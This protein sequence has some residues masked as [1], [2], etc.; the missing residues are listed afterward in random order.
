MRE[1]L[2]LALIALSIAPLV[3][4]MSTSYAKI[5]TVLSI[6]RSALG[7]EGLPGTGI[8]VALSAALTLATMAPVGTTILASL[9]GSGEPSVGAVVGA[10]REPRRTFM[11]KN[12]SPR[13]IERF[14]ALAKKTRA[15]AA[16]SDFSVV[17]PAFVVTELEEALTLGAA[18]LLPFL[19]L[20][21][22]VA[23]VL[24][25]LGTQNLS[26]TQVSFPLKL[27]LFLSVDGLGVLSRAL[28]AS[29]V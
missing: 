25:A 17:V 29:Y 6:L 5:A 11:E 10:A 16:P 9:D 21:L 2:P 14:A 28:V 8:V 1:P 13:E 18:I 20:D 26:A 19:V 12:S 4:L 24:A 27:L 23:N 22:L 7:G 3:L 15:D